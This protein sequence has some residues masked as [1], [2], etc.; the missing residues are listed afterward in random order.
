MSTATTIEQSTTEDIPLRILAEDSSIADHESSH[1]S[2]DPLSKSQQEGEDPV[3]QGTDAQRPPEPNHVE[4]DDTSGGAPSAPET[5]H[6]DKWQL[7]LNTTQ[8]FI[9]LIALLGFLAM[10]YPRSLTTSPTRRASNLPSGKRG[11]ISGT[12]AARRW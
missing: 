1:T 10:L 11:K 8:V 4:V 2:G 7:R 12:S 3:D 9:G 6:V 5:T